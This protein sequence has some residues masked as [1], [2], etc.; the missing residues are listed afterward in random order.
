MKSVD[1]NYTLF[2]RMGNPLRA[3]L[4]CVFTGD[5]DVPEMQSPDVTHA[6]AV[7]SGDSL[8]LMSSR[9]YDDPSYYMKVA[10]AN[11]LDSV[12][13]IPAGESIVFPPVK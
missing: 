13:N 3:E 7:D 9:I 5:G 12:R 8:P 11:N 6:R 4:D 2:D 1:V 10:E